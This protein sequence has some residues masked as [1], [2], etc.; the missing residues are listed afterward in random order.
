[1]ITIRYA[2]TAVAVA[3]GGTIAAE[4]TSI[5]SA[6]EQAVAVEAP[7]P[8]PAAP[9]LSDPRDQNA[10]RALIALARP[11]FSPDRR[12]VAP[13]P[14]AA[15]TTLA[16]V[17]PRLTGTLVSP[18]HKRAVFV[19][20]DKP[21]VMAEGS[22]IDAWTVQEISAGTVTLVGPDGLHMLHV[23]FATGDIT[24]KARVVELPL[25]VR[26]ARTHSRIDVVAS[27]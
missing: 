14:D 11:L 26:P 8:V 16:L 21:A 13:P 10:S 22:R 4:L 15:P 27:K 23:S 5:E 17:L 2:F 18:G 24:H 7:Q 9:P 12:P 3:L 1:M 6:P 19:T 20:G 25:S